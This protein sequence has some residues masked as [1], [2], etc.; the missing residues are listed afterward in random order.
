MSLN[1]PV[2]EG[3]SGA[4]RIDIQ[5][6][7]Y[8]DI[9]TADEISERLSLEPTRSAIKGPRVG[10][11][12]G[13]ASNIPHHLWCLKSENNVAVLEFRSHLDWMLAKL[14]P[15]RDQ[16]IQLRDSGAIRFV[17]TCVMWTEV[18]GATLTL[19]ARHAHALVHL[20][21]DLEFSFADYGDSG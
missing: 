12:T 20:Q 9:Y 8:S 5:A 6:K 19:S 13:H 1:G 18:G 17:L 4:F 21:S 7:I 11:R 15:V 14:L 10:Q 2:S 3:T 16:I